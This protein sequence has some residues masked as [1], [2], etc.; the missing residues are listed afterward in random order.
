MRAAATLAALIAALAWRLPPSRRDVVVQPSIAYEAGGSLWAVA[1]DYRICHTR[2][3]PAAWA[4]ARALVAILT[5]CEA[6]GDG[7]AAVRVTLEH[8][9]R[10]LEGTWHAANGTLVGAFGAVGAGA[11]ARV[12]VRGA[13][14]DGA[15]DVYFAAR[16]GLGVV[17][18]VEGPLVSAPVAPWGALR[19]SPDARGV[20]DALNQWVSEARTFTPTIRNLSISYYGESL[21][22]GA[23]RARLLAWLA[24]AGLPFGSVWVPPENLGPPGPRAWFAA[25]PAPRDRRHDAIARTM[26]ALADRWFVLVGAARDA[27]A[28]ARFHARFGR[29]VLCVL[30][31]EPAGPGRDEARAAL[32]GVPATKWA[33]V[34]DPAAIRTSHSLARMASLGHCGGAYS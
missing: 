9:G 29:R 27:R 28:F 16:R 24:D 22:F 30:I 8:G 7:A 11:R 31:S 17:A 20:A 15:S 33:L 6:P 10:G 32:A 3:A 5:W 14:L 26:D 4:W 34:A 21:A 23:G 19:R 25:R 1:V 2:D 12:R 18:A 13:G